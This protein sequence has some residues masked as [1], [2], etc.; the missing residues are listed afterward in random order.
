[1]N[2]FDVVP[3]GT[4]YVIQIHGCCD[5]RWIIHALIY[6]DT[7]EEANI[8]LEKYAREAN[9]GLQNPFVFELRVVPV[10]NGAV[11]F[12]CV[13]PTISREYVLR[14]GREQVIAEYAATAAGPP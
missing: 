10:V 12:S 8:A 14:V 3:D 2:R 6:R 4:T 9:T 5:N 7:L 11:P 1:M 13:T